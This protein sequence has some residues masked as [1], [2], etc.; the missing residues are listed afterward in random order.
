MRSS[1]QLPMLLE[2]VRQPRLLANSWTLQLLPRKQ[3][4]EKR[5]R[6]SK[7]ILECESFERYLLVWLLSSICYL[8][9]VDAG[10]SLRE[11]FELKVSLKYLTK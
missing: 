4:K 7:E 3:L 8:Y 1:R 5:N 9:K 10:V 2:S 11:D 6:K